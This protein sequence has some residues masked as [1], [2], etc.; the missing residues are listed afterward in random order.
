MKIEDEIRPWSN[1]RKARGQDVHKLISGKLHDAL[2]TAYTVVDP[3]IRALPEDLFEVESR[4]FKHI[5]T[6]DFS[7]EYFRI[8]EDLA[9]NIADQIS[10]AKYLEGYGYYASGLVAALSAATKGK[11]ESARAE[12]FQ[13]LLLSIFADVA[14]AM[15]QFFERDAK[16]DIEAMDIL[17]TAMKALASGNLAHRIGDDV[18]AKIAGTRQDFNEAMEAIEGVIGGIGNNAEEVGNGTHE[19]ARAVEDLSRRTENQAAALEETAASLSEITETVKRTSIGAREATGA[20][21][22]ASEMVTQSSTIMDSAEK[23]MTEISASSAEIAKILTVIDEISVQTN[24]LALNAT[25]E[26]ARAGDAGK[27]FAVV[28]SEVRA[29][30]HRSANEAKSI[31]GLIGSSTQHVENGVKIISDV[32]EALDRTADK[33]SEIDRLLREIAVSAEE[34]ASGIEQINVAVADMDNMTQQNAA[35]VEQ[36]LAAAVTLRDGSDRL[37]ALVRELCA[38]GYD[39]GT[40]VS[41][42]RAG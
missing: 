7:P 3:N 39:Q 42:A 35:M 10:F 28:A 18:P 9:K 11:R 38:D 6:G 4:K 24:L 13:S 16:A 27:G 23:A 15:Q 34:E 21:S 8:Q 14:V 19:I 33:V 20:A 37:K 32:S 36:T 40:T 30:A 5:A 1:D 26:A 22:A 25:V 17:G 2:M 41:F 31:R 29:L 12:L